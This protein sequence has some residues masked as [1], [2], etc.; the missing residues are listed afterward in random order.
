M[1]YSIYIDRI[2]LIL[3]GHDVNFTMCVYY[4]KIYCYM[5]YF[6]AYFDYLWYGCLFFPLKLNCCNC[7]WFP[8]L[9]VILENCA[10]CSVFDKI[11]GSLH[12]RHFCKYVVC[13]IFSLRIL[14]SWNTIKEESFCNNHLMKLN[15]IYLT[16][17]LNTILVLPLFKKGKV[18]KVHPGKIHKIQVFYARNFNAVRF[19]SL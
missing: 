17:L 5:L 15:S 19:F 13:C 3:S 2:L 8:H 11:I 12:I 9:L 10:S 14:R 4:F 18:Q 16:M 7:I 1:Q 6:T